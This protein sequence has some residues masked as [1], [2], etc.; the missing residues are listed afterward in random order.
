M[1]FSE[2]L[3]FELQRYANPAQRQL[4][5][6]EDLAATCISRVRRNIYQ[7]LGALA[8]VTV[9]KFNPTLFR[10]KQQQNA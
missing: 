10:Q 4:N 6:P 2:L 5:Y 8:A 1:P 7:C 9:G 3:F